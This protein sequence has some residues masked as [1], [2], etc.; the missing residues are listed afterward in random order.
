LAILQRMCR[1]LKLLRGSLHSLKGEVGVAGVRTA[2]AEFFGVVVP[3]LALE[4]ADLFDALDGVQYL[5]TDRASF[6][7]MQSF[8]NRVE[9]HFEEDVAATVA[10]VD[11]HLIYSGLPQTDT[12]CLFGFLVRR[13]QRGRGEAPNPQAGDNV[14]FLS[15]LPVGDAGG[16][17]T[18]EGRAPSPIRIFTGDLPGLLRPLYLVVW[19]HSRALF[20]FCVTERVAKSAPFHETLD[21]FA[22]EEIRT[23]LPAIV[24][25][26]SR[27]PEPD[28]YQYIY[29]NHTNLAL[30]SNLRKPGVL[31]GSSPTAVSTADVPELM[32]YFETMHADFTE[33]DTLKEIVVKTRRHEQWVAGRRCGNREFYAAFDPKQTLADVNKELR[34][35]NTQF[36]LNAFVDY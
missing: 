35:I 25:R 7:R 21:R 16:F 32:G 26:V 2:L 34:I 1:M 22:R 4:T 20:G 18:V 14:L 11:D 24:E 28:D 8:I 17:L 33:S 3:L 15:A 23:T 9:T 13:R 6:L 10:L 12:R 5:A 30:K 19:Q 27:H 31:V 29:F 36:F